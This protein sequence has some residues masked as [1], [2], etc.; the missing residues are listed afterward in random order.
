M[1][2]PKLRVQFIH[3]LKSS[4]QGS[5]AVFLASRFDATTP[6]MDTRD[7]AAAIETQARALAEIRP[8]VVVGSSF[9]G[10]IAVALLA[11]GLWRGP[12]L[13]LA[14]AAAKLGVTDPLPEGVPVT[15]VH[16][17]RDAIVPLEDSRALAR[18]GTPSLV[19]L[20]EVDDEH[21]LQSLVDSG[22]LAELVLELA[23]RRS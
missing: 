8:D 14:P 21:R 11:R 2:E 1:S 16:G 6:S 5:K 19:V 17:V 23:A 20:H 13:L 9:G 15:I 4:P 10:A 18:T 7:L 22:L 3:G 12:T